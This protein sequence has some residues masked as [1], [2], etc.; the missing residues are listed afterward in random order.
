METD[1]I[2]LDFSDEDIV[3]PKRPAAVIKEV[4]PTLPSPAPKL[5]IDQ[6]DPKLLNQEYSHW[7]VLW[8]YS[9]LLT[10]EDL[11]GDK[12]MGLLV[13]R[14]EDNFCVLTYKG[15]GEKKLEPFGSNSLAA[16]SYF[17]DQ[18]KTYTLNDWDNRLIFEP[19]PGKYAIESL[20]VLTLGGVPSLTTEEM[21]KTFIENLESA[22]L[23]ALE[24]QII[25]SDS[26]F[27]L[28]DL[29]DPKD[30]FAQLNSHKVDFDLF[31]GVNEQWLRSVWQVIESMASE[32]SSRAR[33]D[34]L[35]DLSAHLQSKI[36]IERLDTVNSLIGLK[37]T[38]R[39]ISFI[40]DCL[41]YRQFCQSFCAF[42]RHNK[43]VK[44]FLEMFDWR[45]QKLVSESNKFEFVVDAFKN[46]FLTVHYATPVGVKSVYQ[47]ECPQ[48]RAVFELF[49]TLKRAFLWKA[50]PL[51]SFARFLAQKNSNFE[52]M[53]KVDP[54][55]F[56]EMFY[57]SSSRALRSGQTSERE[58]GMFL[59]LYE[60]A[61]GEVICVKNPIGVEIN[62]LLVHSVKVEGKNSPQSKFFDGVELFSNHQ[63]R[64]NHSEHTLTTPQFH[65]LDAS[66]F[67][68]RYVIF[69]V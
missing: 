3:L 32:L 35:I 28:A 58:Q 18:F 59:V 47:L 50:F 63:L 45:A 25:V 43:T 26:T 40:E 61:V 14:N 33:G 34:Q 62:R 24:Q 2:E 38:L 8:P 1:K 16:V 60:V 57:D 11:V 29:L 64:E 22:R 20:N 19:Q 5:P 44:D 52:G 30:F 9:V 56:G 39:L 23:T 42:V 53:T 37:M 68:P 27:P 66:Q 36:K 17:C 54:K 4:P 31:F 48:R 65:I 21:K 51:T 55:C 6:F 41:H 13:L 49:L 46:S 10:L 15:H 69:F 67:I 12:K 7:E